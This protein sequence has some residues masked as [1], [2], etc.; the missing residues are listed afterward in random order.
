MHLNSQVQRQLHTVLTPKTAATAVPD[1]LHKLRHE[2]PESSM[3]SYAKPSPITHVTFE[4]KQ[5]DA[6]EVH[7]NLSNCMSACFVHV[8]VLQAV[9]DQSK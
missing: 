8:H 7:N 6:T 2:V 3:L 5:R 4:P 9:L 1:T